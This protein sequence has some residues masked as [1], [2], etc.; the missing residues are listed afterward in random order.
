MDVGLKTKG[1]WYLLGDGYPP[2][3]SQD[4][5]AFEEALKALSKDLQ[6]I[7]ILKARSGAAVTDDDSWNPEDRDG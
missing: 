4:S 7:G 1:T 5:K 6:L 3:W 2:S